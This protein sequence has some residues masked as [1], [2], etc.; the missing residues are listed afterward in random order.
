MPVPDAL[1]SPQVP[2]LLTIFQPSPRMLD[3]L[4]PLRRAS[5]DDPPVQYSEPVQRRT[6]SAILF[7]SCL[8]SD[9]VRCRMGV[10]IRTQI[11]EFAEVTSGAQPYEDVLLEKRRLKFSVLRLRQNE[12]IDN[13]INT[14]VKVRAIHV[15]DPYTSSSPS[16]PLPPS[17]PKLL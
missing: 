16:S 1:L 14:Q 3:Q 7:E 6:L 13:I 10:I 11:D 4:V 12:G 2:S 17:P 9:L 8:L 15:P 5:F